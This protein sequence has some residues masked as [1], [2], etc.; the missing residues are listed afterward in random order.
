MTSPA[1]TKNILV[2]AT[3][4]VASIKIPELVRLFKEDPTVD[5]KV[6]PT[7]A[8]RFFFKAEDVDA[9]MYTDQQEWEMWKKKTDPVLHIDLRNWA[10]IMV[11]AP[12]DANTLGKLANGL[13]DNLLTC[14]LRAWDPCRPVVVCPAMNTNMW[15]HPFT[16]KH[17]D[18]LQKSLNFNV[19]DP[20]SKQL[21]CGDIGIGAM[22]EPACI[23]REVLAL[24]DKPTTPNLT[25][26]DLI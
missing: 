5:V 9:D 20:I 3:G 8:A 16:N 7:E 4:S 1:K 10:D 15:N 25:E 12:L 21:A 24:L 19:I 13:C 23:V 18:V 17:L 14:V 11:V 22:A 2:G 26:G 6:V